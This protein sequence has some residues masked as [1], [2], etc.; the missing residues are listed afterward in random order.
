MKGPDRALYSCFKEVELKNVREPSF[1]LETL[2]FRMH[3]FVGVQDKH[4]YQNRKHAALAPA[5]I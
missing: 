2:T 3:Q 1:A 5:Y 4:G